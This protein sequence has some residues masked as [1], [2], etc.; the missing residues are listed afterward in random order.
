MVSPVPWLDARQIVESSGLLPGR[1]RWPN[2]P[3]QPPKVGSDTPLW[4]EVQDVGEGQLPIEL[5]GNGAWEERGRVLFTIYAPAH[6][7]TLQARRMAKSI[8]NLFRGLPPRPVVYLDAS[9]GSGQIVDE[10]GNVW[11]LLLSIG[12]KYQDVPS[13]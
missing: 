5:S 1:V 9:V 8:A 2:E 12:F 6:S 4:A 13:S 10:K 11:G 3:F 7:G